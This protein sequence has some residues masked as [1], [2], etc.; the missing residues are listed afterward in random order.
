[1]FN[2]IDYMLSEAIPSSKEDMSKK[3]KLGDNR[4][5]EL[6]KNSN[7]PENPPPS[8]LI[9]QQPSQQISEPASGEKWSLDSIPSSKEPPT[10]DKGKWDLN[11]PPSSDEEFDINNDYTTG[12]VAPDPRNALNQVYKLKN[13][14]MRIQSLDEIFSDLADPRYFELKDTLLKA[15]EL[16]TK[17]LIPNLTVYVVNLDEIIEKYEDI[18]SKISAKTLEMFNVIK[19]EQED[20][21][22][23]SKKRS[24]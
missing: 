1:M 17:I 18:V 3:W 2:I 11:S 12:M 23:K 15:K 21:K 6:V 5:N 8:K 14:Y 22:N 4:K 19:K 7:T 10:D 13:V 9:T 24:V 16:F 20:P